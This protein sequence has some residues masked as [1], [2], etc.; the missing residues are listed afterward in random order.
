MDVRFGVNTEVET[1]P[2]A[3]VVDEATTDV[4][5]DV[6]SFDEMAIRHQKIRLQMPLQPRKQ[7][8]QNPE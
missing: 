3:E 8:R 4:D 1:N 7:K 2:D 6:V 5:M